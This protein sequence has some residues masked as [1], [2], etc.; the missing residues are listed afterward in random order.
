MSIDQTIAELLRKVN[1]LAAARGSQFSHLPDVK[2]IAVTKNQSTIAI[3]SALAAGIGIIAENRVQEAL[4]K[5]EDIG[6]MAEWHL[7]GHLQ[8]N[9]AKLIVPF[10]RL[11][12]S[13]DSKSLAIEIAKAAAKLNKR[14]DV[15]MQIN[16]SGEATK[17]GIPPNQ[18]LELAGFLSSLENIRLCGCMTIAPFCDDI[19]ET[20]PVFR[21]LFYLFQEIKSLNFPN[22][23]LEWVS[24]GMTNDYPVAIEE[25]AN[26]LRIGTGIFGKRC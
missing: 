16:I 7:I 12:H 8:T 6:E 3:R 20:R 21:E 1:A 26:L 4:Q 14:Q 17:F 22:T 19:E 24:M 10:C 11:I 5:Y 15:L 25:G 13:L 2:V 23:N 9:K 18:A